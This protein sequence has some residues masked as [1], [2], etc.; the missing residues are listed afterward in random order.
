VEL[1]HLRYFQTVAEEL[2]FSRAAERL[3]MSQPPLSSQIKQLEREF[4]VQLFNRS[5]TGVQLTEAGRIVL[6][7]TRRILGDAASLERLTR[8]LR[9]G[10]YGVVRIGTVGS[11]LT[12][13]LPELLRQAGQAFPGVSIEIEELDTGHQ[14]AAFASNL[15]DIGVIRPPSHAADLDSMELS[16]ERLVAV[17]GVDHPLAQ[18]DV[19]AVGELSEDPFLL[20]SRQNGVGLWDTV[21]GCCVAG[22][23]T[24]ADIVDND[25]IFTIVAMVAAGRGVSVLPESTRVHQLP[26]VTY[27]NLNVDVYT[28]LEMVW[29]RSRMTPVISN[30][31]EFSRDYLARTSANIAHE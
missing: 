28:T 25:S 27:V 20:F 2:S 11:A 31:V 23:F 21:V 8:E 16:R 10:N 1:R 26:G 22:G 6:D 5:G 15:I 17:V 7:S 12:G 4:G 14:D 24:P 9:R 3:Q 30:L 13:V 18:R 29:S 19:I